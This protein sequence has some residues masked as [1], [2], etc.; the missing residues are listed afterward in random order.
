MFPHWDGAWMKL[1]SGKTRILRFYEVNAMAADDLWPFL[2]T[3]IN[4]PSKKWDEITYPFPNFNG[5]TVEVWEWIN[6]FIPHIVM[7]AIIHPC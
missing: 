1:N 6:N 5:G 7:D 3:W 4:M 2:L